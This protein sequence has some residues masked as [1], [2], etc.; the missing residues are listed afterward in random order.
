[1]ILTE[2]SHEMFDGAI[3]DVAATRIQASYRGYKTRS[4]AKKGEEEKPRE[5][6]AG[7]EDEAKKQVRR[8]GMY[9]SNKPPRAKNMG[10]YP[11]PYIPHTHHG[12]SHSNLVI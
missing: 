7:D 9:F 1:M 3:Q 6:D 8:Q 11:H 4:K 2:W 12:C 10:V 5:Q